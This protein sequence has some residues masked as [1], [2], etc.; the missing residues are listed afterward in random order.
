[1]PEIKE[2]KTGFATVLFNSVILLLVLTHDLMCFRVN[3]G[4][5]EVSAV[6]WSVNSRVYIGVNH[7]AKIVTAIDML[8]YRET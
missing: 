3:L 4:I 7:T 8:L 1:M 5:G 2:L 6:K